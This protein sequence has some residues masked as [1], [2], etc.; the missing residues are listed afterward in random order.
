MFFVIPFTFLFVLKYTLVIPLSITVIT[1]V[2]LLQTIP[3]E[4]S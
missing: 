1:F 4:S 3:A 2:S